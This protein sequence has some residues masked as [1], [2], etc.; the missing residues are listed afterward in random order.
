MISKQRSGYKPQYWSNNLQVHNFRIPYKSTNDEFP[1]FLCSDLH[2]ES[3]AFDK[4][5]LIEE[6]DEAATKDARIF[7][8]GDVFDLIIPGDHKRYRKHG[9]P[10][11]N[12]DDYVNEAVQRAYELLKPYAA[13]IDMIGSG[14]HEVEYMKRSGYDPISGLITLLQKDSGHP[15]R[16]G[17][18]EG[19]IVLNFAQGENLNESVRKYTI[20]YNHGQGTGATEVTFGVIDLQRRS[21]IRADLIWLGH[22]HKR[23]GLVLPTEIGV[24]REGNIYEKERKGVITGTYL[25][26]FIQY[27]ASKDGY[28]DGYGA[29][30]MRTP[31]LKGGVMLTIKP[32]VSGAVGR[33]LI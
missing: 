26:T 18:Y 14:N 11:D 28:R 29:E 32:K 1:I 24:D 4:R 27:D 25:K 5:F 31:Q 33:L 15:I 2:C 22:K 9:D 17:A 12:R 23:N 6:L 10:F 3:L 20:Y 7:I 8:N 13:Q 16:H 19:F 30:K 21:Y